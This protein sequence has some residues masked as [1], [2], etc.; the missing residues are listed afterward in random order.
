MKLQA[1]GFKARLR[2]RQKRQNYEDT[3][4]YPLEGNK[5]QQ[6]QKVIVKHSLH[7]PG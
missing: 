5:E 4:R 1:I 2:Q 6:K 7:Y 3:K